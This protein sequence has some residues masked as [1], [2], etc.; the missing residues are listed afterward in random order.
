MG[1]KIPSINAQV[2]FIAV[3]FCELA[4]MLGEQEYLAVNQLAA[5]L[6]RKANAETSSAETKKALGELARRLLNP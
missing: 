2:E 4:K 1:E 6:E 3:A 5:S